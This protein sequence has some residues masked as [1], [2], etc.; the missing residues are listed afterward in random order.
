MG[1]KELDEVGLVLFADALQVEDFSEIGVGF[2]GDVDEVGLD[3]GFGRGRPNLEG[4]EDGIEAGHGLR[5]AFGVGG[6]WS[7]VWRGVEGEEFFEAFFEDVAIEEHLQIISG[8]FLALERRRS[9]LL[10]SD[11]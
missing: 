3:E 11:F 1:L 8:E 2:V 5:D 6:G 7:G 4:F 10:S 9:H